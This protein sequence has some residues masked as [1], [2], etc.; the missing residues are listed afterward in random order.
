MHVARRHLALSVALILAAM[1]LHVPAAQA[2]P[3]PTVE[4]FSPA[5]G[6]VGTSVSISGSHFQQA[7][8]VE[9]NG[10]DQTTFTVNS[11]N[12]ITAAVPSGATT[13]K[14]R[15]TTPDG[16]D[17]SRDDFTVSSSC[18]PTI[19]GFSPTSGPVGSSVTISGSRLVGT[20]AVRFNVTNAS[21]FS[22]NPSGTQLT[23]TVPSGATTGR[24]TVTTPAG[25]ATSAQDFTVTGAPP[26]PT[27]SSFVPITGPVG[28]S[29][30]ITGTH[31]TGATDVRFKN[32]SATE[33]TVNS[34]TRITAVV[35]SGAMTGKIGVTTPGGTGTSAANFTVTPPGSPTITSFSPTSGP[36]GTAVTIEGTNFTGTTAVR[37]GGTA[38]GS[39]TVV[40]S[41][42]LTAVV[43]SGARTGP[44]TVTN[45]NG[46][47]TSATDFTVTAAFHERRI[48]LS[49]R[50]HLVA[51]G[52]VS[53][54]DG[55]AP[56]Y[57]NVTVRIQRQ[58]ASGTW[59]TVELTL[60][61][62]AGSY[63]ERIADRAGRYRAVARKL[64]LG[65]DVCRRAV[66]PAVLNA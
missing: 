46:T 8:L 36:S 13:G 35:P 45:A 25:S 21:T 63:R 55:F 44:I 40:T 43:P 32:T 3:P 47:G 54:V 64:V 34:D 66:S 4:G 60:T 11:S 22:W 61:D 39:F 1:L 56:C 26:A 6:P 10:V 5:C 53:A 28:T 14:I 12:S 27:I 16:S 59:R 18:A 9:F 49:L 23:A 51:R 20:T 19:A 65:N 31:F 41:T 15:V 17:E 62:G 52:F 42:R 30:V 37:F 2:A 57:A 7:T 24:I 50:R 58:R 48:T 29:V 38:S 33:F